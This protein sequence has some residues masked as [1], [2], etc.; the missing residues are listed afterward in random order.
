MG[1]FV[2]TILLYCCMQLTKAMDKTNLHT[3]TANGHSN[4]W[5]C[6]FYHKRF[7]LGVTERSF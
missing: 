1:M 3:A 6:Y 5:I 7:K 2:F 4:Q